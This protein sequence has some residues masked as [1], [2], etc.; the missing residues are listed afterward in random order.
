MRHDLTDAGW[1]GRAFVRA[2][3]QVLPVAALLA[4]L[5]GSWYIHL[6]MPLFVLL[7]A[8]CGSDD[9]GSTARTVTV[10][11]SAPAST[12]VAGDPTTGSPLLDGE[13]GDD[14]LG[15]EGVLV[16]VRPV[17]AAP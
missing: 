6:M 14:A 16:D 12:S 17:G 3:V 4:L 1:R 15:R 13:V 7:C 2:L 11:A 10:T 9:A 8:A 5:P